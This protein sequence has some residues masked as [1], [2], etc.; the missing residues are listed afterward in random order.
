MNL[1]SLHFNT[2][3]RF[4][5]YHFKGG[6]KNANHSEI[7]IVRINVSDINCSVLQLLVKS[8]ENCHRPLHITRLLNVMYRSYIFLDKITDQWHQV[9]VEGL[10]VTKADLLVGE[11]WADSN[12]Q[13]MVLGQDFRHNASADSRMLGWTRGRVVALNNSHHFFINKKKK[14]ILRDVYAIKVGLK[15]NRIVRAFS[16]TDVHFDMKFYTQALRHADALALA[17]AFYGLR[18]WMTVR[19]CPYRGV[20]RDTF[21]IGRNPVQLYAIRDSRALVVTVDPQP[22]GVDPPEVQLHITTKVTHLTE[23]QGKGQGPTIR[24]PRL[25]EFNFKT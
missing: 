2:V 20:V 15:V 22:D 17:V 6:T 16:D 19:V 4:V 3:H 18:S 13:M 7:S 25:G 23:V 12:S 24:G 11:P 9:H 5:G 10:L 21:C 1:C 8:V 14:K